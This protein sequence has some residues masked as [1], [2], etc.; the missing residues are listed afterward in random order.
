MV[1]IIRGKRI[2]V[3]KSKLSIKD[4]SEGNKR[5]RRVKIYFIG[6]GAGDPELLTIKGQKIIKKADVIIYAGSLVNKEILKWAKRTTK[7]YDSASMN[8]N[9]VFNVYKKL[10]GKAKIVARVH[11]GDPS[12]YGAIQEQISWCER[13]GIEYEIIPGVSSFCAAGA[14]LRQELTLPGISQTVIITRISGKTNVPSREKLKNLAK[15]GS[16]LIIFLSIS[17]IKQVVKE[18]LY[19]Y[20]KTTPAAVVYRASWPDEKVITGSLSDIAAKVK[21]SGIKKQA[22]IF[23]GDVL[24]KKGFRKSRLY[25]KTFSHMYRKAK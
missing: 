14:S 13:Q 3:V 18:L 10:S 7:L 11:S 22:L 21:T 16:T 4:V 20:K 24:K 15:I 8:L 2:G 9:E 17:R 23:V 12:L 19:G 1:K 5:K 6:A 25:D